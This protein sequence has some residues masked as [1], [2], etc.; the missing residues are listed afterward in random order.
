LLIGLPLLVAAIGGGSLVADLVDRP[1]QTEFG[2]VIRHSRL[3]AGDSDTPIS[4]RQSISYVANGFIHTPSDGDRRIGFGQL[5]FYNPADTP[6]RVEVTLYFDNRPPVQV[7]PFVLKPLSNAHL[8]HLPE[9]WAQ[10]FDGSGAWGARFVA[11]RPVLVDH[12]LVAGVLPP[13]VNHWAENAAFKGGAADTIAVAKLDRIWHFGDGFRLRWSTPE[14]HMPFNEYE[15]FHILNPGHED[16]SVTMY[17]YYRNGSRG[18]VSFEVKAERVRIFSNFEFAK[19]NI[20]HG[21]KVVS[22][23]PVLVQCERFIYDYA[24]MTEWGAWIHSLRPGVP[25]SELQE[26][27]GGLDARNTE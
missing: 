25:H 15:W 4:H 6:N 16:A 11:D 24:N 23:V 19:L 12:W 18:A 1:V 17:F 2:T 9:D 5:R 22:S 8:F 20:S 21:V 26:R 7:D 14:G 13:G 3:Y 27:G 10:Y